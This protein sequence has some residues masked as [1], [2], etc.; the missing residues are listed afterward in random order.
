[1]NKFRR[2]SPRCLPPTSL[3]PWLAAC[4]VLGQWKEPPGVALHILIDAR[5]GIVR[6]NIM[7]KC[8]SEVGF[9]SF[10]DPPTLVHA[11][12]DR[13]ARR[14]LEEEARLAAEIEARE[15]PY[16][17]AHRAFIE[18]IGGMNL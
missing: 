15:R 17:A 12:L 16:D 3:P 9:P 14:V 4:A 5:F 6:Y 2:N 11:E 7:S 18:G 8:V 1:M 10:S 13:V